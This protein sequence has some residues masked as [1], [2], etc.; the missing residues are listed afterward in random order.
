MALIDKILV[1]TDFSGNSLIATGQAG[2]LA[3]HFHAEVTLLHVDEFPVMRP[4]T[5]EAH[6]AQH[7]TAR[8]QELMEFGKR[9]CE[10]WRSSGWCAAAIQPR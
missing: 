3:R 5:T 8:R 6:R 10:K 7:M 9:N 4:F 1:P 2:A